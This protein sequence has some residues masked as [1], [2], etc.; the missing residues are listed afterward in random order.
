MPKLNSVD[1][2]FTAKLQ[3]IL[4]V[5][6]KL[7]SESFNEYDNYMGKRLSFNLNY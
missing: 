6:L 1:C 3:R 5:N 7:V 4:D 2:L